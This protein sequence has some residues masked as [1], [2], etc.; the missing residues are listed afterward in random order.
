M[1]TVAAIAAL[2]V[3]PCSSGKLGIVPDDVC[4]KTAQSQ[5]FLMTERAPVGSTDAGLPGLPTKMWVV[6]MQMPATL[7]ISEDEGAPKANEWWLYAGR[8]KD[9]EMKRLPPRKL[10]PPELPSIV[11]LNESSFA[12]ELPD[13]PMYP[14]PDGCEDGAVL[15]VTFRAPGGKV[16]KGARHN[17]WRRLTAVDVLASPLVKAAFRRGE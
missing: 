15:A 16:V 13:V 17:C 4:R 6:A 2:A 8:S 11:D 5:E 1:L 14:H 3:A 9:G 12:D 10:L 7:P